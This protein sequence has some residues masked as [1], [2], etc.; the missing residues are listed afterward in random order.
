MPT[1]ALQRRVR[2]CT[3]GISRAGLL[4]RPLS[5]PMRFT[6]LTMWPSGRPVSLFV[7]KMLT[8][9][10]IRMQRDMETLLASMPEAAQR[11]V[12]HQFH[13]EKSLD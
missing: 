9:M 2:H 10:R 8:T 7:R 13:A 12:L 6:A 5:E 11:T 4:F 1:T 3:R